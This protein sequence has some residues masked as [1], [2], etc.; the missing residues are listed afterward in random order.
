MTEQM[1]QAKRPTTVLAGRYGHPLHPALVA[2]PIGAWSAS[3]ILDIASRFIHDAAT[4]SHAA[5]WLLGLGVLGALAAATFGFLDLF[6]IPTGTRAFRVGLL[7]MTINLTATVLFAAA[8]ILRHDDVAPADGTSTG[9]LVLSVVAVLL[10]ATGGYLGGELAYRYGVRVA[11]ETTQATGYGVG[12]HS[13][14]AARP[15][16]IQGPPRDH[17]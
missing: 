7:H 3:V 15:G 5:W 4:A 8:W 14:T 9:Y 6:A 11:D 1:H 17:H 10:V 12:H 13:I 16:S 2:L